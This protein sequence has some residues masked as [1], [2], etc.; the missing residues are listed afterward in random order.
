MFF[1]PSTVEDRYLMYQIMTTVATAF[2]L[3]ALA[4]SLSHKRSI[5]PD[6]TKHWLRVITFLG[7]LVSG[8]ML[9]FIYLGKS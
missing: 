4:A 1:L 3:I 7:S 2:A 8:N 6:G 5:R 9:S